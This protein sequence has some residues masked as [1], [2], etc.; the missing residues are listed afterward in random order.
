MN[1]PKSPRLKVIYILGTSRSGSTILDAAIGTAT[2]AI[3]TG[4]LGH[5]FWAFEAAEGE[6]PSATVPYCSC[7]RLVTQCSLWSV[8]WTELAANGRRSV[9]R[10]DTRRFETL[11]LSVPSAAAARLVH[12]RAFVRHQSDL[13]SMLRSVA[14]NASAQIV[15]DS[16]KDP[17]RGW[18]YSL[19]PAQEF[20]VRFIHLVRDGRSVLSSMM[21]HY[22]PDRLTSVAGYW[23]RPAAA[24]FSTLHWIYMNL[25]SSLLGSANRH[26]YLLIR[27]EDFVS[28]PVETLTSIESFAEIDLSESRR[29][30]TTGTSLASGH[31]LC[32]NRA[33][34]APTLKLKSSAETREPLA[35]GP[36]MIFLA[37]AGWLQWYYSQVSPS[38]RG[39]GAT[40]STVR[41]R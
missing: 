6:S 40:N 23:P 10:E 15:I 18:L 33:K 21:S 32:G 37:L 26:R 41:S 1:D 34:S 5:I 3:S 27:Y 31:L 29:R 12:S 7:G 22:H 14:R 30:V 11:A 2:S 35:L 36:S 20:D 28:R 16:T 38:N 13:G 39:R 25:H 24:F 19:L 4:E 17:G 8:V 9:I